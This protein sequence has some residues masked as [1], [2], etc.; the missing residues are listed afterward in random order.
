[1]RRLRVGLG[2][3]NVTVGDIA[4]NT[5]KLQEWIERGRAQGC[6]LLAFPELAIT[7]YPP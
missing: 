3:V 5:R 1:M 4:G 7:G 2:Q 6:D